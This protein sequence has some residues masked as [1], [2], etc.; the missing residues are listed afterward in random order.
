[1]TTTT[2]SPAEYKPPTPNERGI[3]FVICMRHGNTWH[4]DALSD[5]ERELRETS[6]HFLD[7][8]QGLEPDYC[9]GRWFVLPCG[10]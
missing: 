8:Q 1:M 6:Q 4:L 2:K 7:T 9:E 10:R 5:S 3:I